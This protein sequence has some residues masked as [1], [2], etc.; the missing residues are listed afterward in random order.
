MAMRFMTLIKSVEDSSFGPPPPALFQAIARLGEEAKQAGV[1]VDTGGLMPTMAGARVRLQGGQISASDGSF[2][3]GQETV[4]AYAIF[5]VESKQQA[6][7]W[8]RKFMQ[9]H[10]EHWK[11]WQ[12]ETEVRQMI[13]MPPPSGTRRG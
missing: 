2:G 12:G 8:A 7:E 5:D 1:L 13:N 3:S 4:T 6:I 9:A 10:Q 11:Q